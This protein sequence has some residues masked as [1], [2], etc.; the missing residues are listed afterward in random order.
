MGY[1]Y[2]PRPVPTAPLAPVLPLPPPHPQPLVDTHQPKVWASGPGCGPRPGPWASPRPEHG[3]APQTPARHRHR[4]RPWTGRGAA[5]P[6]KRPRR[7]A[8]TGRHSSGPTKGA[9]P[10]PGR[11]LGP[12]GRTGLACPPRAVAGGEAEPGRRS[13]LGRPVARTKIRSGGGCPALPPTGGDRSGIRQSPPEAAGPPLD[14]LRAAGGWPCASGRAHRPM[15][16][17]AWGQSRRPLTHHHRD[18]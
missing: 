4:H 10:R 16:L 15:L 13:P 2:H 5:A 12:A 14:V 7:Q 17:H 8:R 3:H 6:S 11:R 9:G 1:W 18:C